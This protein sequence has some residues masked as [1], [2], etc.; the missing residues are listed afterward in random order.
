[1]WKDNDNEKGPLRF[2]PLP[3]EDGCRFYGHKPFGVKATVGKDINMMPIHF[4]SPR[5]IACIA[6][7]AVSLEQHYYY[8]S[9][10]WSNH[11]CVRVTYPNGNGASI[12]SYPGWEDE[13]CWD[14]ALLKDGELLVEDDGYDYTW[15]NLTEADVI[16]ICDYIFFK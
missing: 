11:Y 1:M 6:R 15:S 4:L 5:T 16:E 9:W 8:H 2:R 13:A 12:V 7:G 3:K 14:V 10:G